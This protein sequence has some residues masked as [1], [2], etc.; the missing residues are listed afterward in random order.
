MNLPPELLA[1][2]AGD[3]DHAS[4]K[5]LRLVDHVFEDLCSPLVFA[6]FYMAMFEDSLA[7]LEVSE[8]YAEHTWSKARCV[9]S[10]I[11]AR[12]GSRDITPS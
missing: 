10:R 12:L 4:Q 11:D 5:Q 1:H 8:Q 6:H 2:I 3:C 9:M 7:R